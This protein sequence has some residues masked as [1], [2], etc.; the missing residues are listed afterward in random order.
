MKGNL[1]LLLAGMLFSYPALAAELDLSKLPP[2][3]P[4]KDVSFEKD[5][6][7]IFKDSCIRCHGEERP[8]AG[9]RLDSAEAVVKGSKNG[10][11]IVPGNSAKSDLVIA[12][13]RI[14]PEIAMPPIRQGR[15]SNRQPAPDGAQNPG[16]QQ[17]PQQGPPAKPLTPEQVGLVRAWI[18]QGAK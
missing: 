17:R 14:D 11:V 5:I 18:D 8:K 13:S 9:L 3:S 6:L 16:G 2:A 12:I 7:P 10:K 4:K 15:A 1:S